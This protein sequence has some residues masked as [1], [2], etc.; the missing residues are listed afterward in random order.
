MHTILKKGKIMD[1]K[2]SLSLNSI[3]RFGVELEINAFDNRN[4]PLNHESGKLPDGIYYVGNLVQKTTDDN[5][6]IHKWGNDHHNQDWIIK[7]DAS[8]GMEVCTPVLKGWLGLM[9]VCK[10]VQAFSEDV[11]IK[12]DDR[13]S[14]HVHVDVSDLS[15]SQLAS[16]ITWWVKC[17]PV[18]L[19][20][21]PNNRKKNQYCQCIGQTDIFEH[22][23][24]GL[25]SHDTLISRLGQSK[26]YTMNTFHYHNDKR[27]TIEFR[28]MD[29][30]CC[31]DAYMTKNWVRLL[32]HF[33]EMAIS[34]GLPHPYK[35]GD[36]WS[37]Y[38]WLDPVDVF[39]FLGF[40]P[41]QYSLSP[42]LNQVRNWFIDRLNTQKDSEL[43]GVLSNKGRRIAHEQIVKLAE[44]LTEIDRDVFGEKYRI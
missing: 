9:Q 32:L 15:K 19:D 27:K 23:E 39:E 44:S 13:C 37:S 3:R 6:T 43:I 11:K 36:K 35:F 38:C 8:C 34:K 21:V 17:E 22:V 16:I 1:A 25:L 5:V 20:S 40:M 14:L 41:D 33:V 2:V 7:P 18:F 26:Y 12:A 29:A 10:V 24:D 42:G 4:R 28:I 30:K 31:Q